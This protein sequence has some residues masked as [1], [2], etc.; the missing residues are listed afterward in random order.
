MQLIDAMD[1]VLTEHSRSVQLHGDW[2]DYSTEQMMAQIIHELMI[3]AGDAE[4]RG[5]VHGDHGVVRELAQVS[6]CCIKAIM[7]LSDRSEGTLAETLRTAGA[8]SGLQG[9]ALP[10][11]PSPPQREESSFNSPEGETNGT[12]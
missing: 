10:A 2:R 1:M 11:S 4:S 3:E 7:V 12:R 5:D 8:H 6:A 9:S